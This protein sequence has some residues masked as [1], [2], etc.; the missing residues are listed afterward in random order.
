MVTRSGRRPGNPDTRNAILQSAKQ[1]FAANGF[2]PTSMRQIAAAAGVDPALIHHYFASKDRL[3]LATIEVFV[4]IPTK[5]AQVLA[6]DPERF[7]WNLVATVLEVWD[8]P[9]GASLIVAFRAA[10]TDAAAAAMVRDFLT[11]AVIASLVTALPLP[12]D[13]ALRRAGLIA[14]QMIGLLAGR[15]LLALPPLVAMPSDDVVAAVGPTL[16]RY[17]YEPL[18]PADEVLQTSG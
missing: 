17:L 4:D 16:Q 8:S 6:G 12:P 11:D 14:S 7:G 5:L 15:Y 13:D 18:D 1:L 2:S 9:D 10:L 3:F